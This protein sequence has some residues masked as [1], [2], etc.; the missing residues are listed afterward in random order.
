MP[1]CMVL[2]LSLALQSLST[3]SK[4][5]SGVS[6]LR[7]QG[8]N[9]KVASDLAGVVMKNQFHPVLLARIVSPEPKFKGRVDEGARK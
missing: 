2:S 3:W 7:E 4:T 5:I 1:Y 9:C 6:T 8:A